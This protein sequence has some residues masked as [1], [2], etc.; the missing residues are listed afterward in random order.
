[1]LGRPSKYVPIADLLAGAIR[2]GEWAAGDRLPSCSQLSQDYGISVSTAVRV[3]K[4][5]C[6]RRLAYKV[7]GRGHYVLGDELPWPDDSTPLYVRIAHEVALRVQK[8]SYPVL[9]PMSK[10][11]Q[12]EFGTCRT[13]VVK[14]SRVLRE[15]G[16]VR[17]ARP[18]RLAVVPESDRPGQEQWEALL[19][20]LARP[21]E[22]GNGNRWRRSPAGDR[23][24]VWQPGKESSQ[25][26]EPWPDKGQ[27]RLD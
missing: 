12:A 19:R 26:P 17:L 8:G 5:L 13:T 22:V 20:E 23:R 25:G 3:L 2:S 27:V 16:W 11:L 7:R 4:E 1:M 9:L 10:E 15:A 6:R 18:K 24:W 14:A 21:K